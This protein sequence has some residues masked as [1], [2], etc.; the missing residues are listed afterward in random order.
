MLV[1]GIHPVVRAACSLYLGFT[2]Q[3]SWKNILLYQEFVLS[4]QHNSLEKV[5]TFEN[6]S[7]EK[8]KPKFR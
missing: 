6:Y 1:R 7:I 5:S 8:V 2:L 3:F 4:L